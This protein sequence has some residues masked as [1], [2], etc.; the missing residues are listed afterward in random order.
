MAKEKI[1]KKKKNG[2]VHSET[3][4]LEFCILLHFII[5]SYSVSK[6]K[7]FRNPMTEQVIY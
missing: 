2:E 3:A 5:G 1:K 4:Y 6:R 7:E